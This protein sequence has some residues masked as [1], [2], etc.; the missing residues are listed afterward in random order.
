M[1]RGVNS[2]PPATNNDKPRRPAGGWRAAVAFILI[3]LAAL[4]LRLLFL[5]RTQLWG[6]EINFV[7]IL[8]QHALTPWQ[9]FLHYWNIVVGM[10]QLPLPGVLLNIHQQL[11]SLFIADP[12]RN[13]FLLRLPGALAGALAVALSYRLGR[14]ILP[15]IVNAAATAMMTACYFPVFYSREVYCYPFVILCAAG[16]FLYFW[17]CLFDPSCATAAFLALF[18]WLAALGLT[19]FGCTAGIAAMALLAGGWGLWNWRVA[20]DR[21]RSIRAWGTLGV[22]L[23]ALL[24]VAPYWWRIL[25]TDN[26]HI[27]GESSV[28]VARILHDVCSKFF[29]GDRLIPAALAWV[30]LL[31]GLGALWRQRE[32]PAPARMAVLLLLLIALFLT[33]LT[34]KSQYLSSRYF[35]VLTPLVYPVFAAGL[36]ALARGLAALFHRA[37]A[38]RAIMAGLVSAVLAA[39]LGLFLPQLYQVRE[40]GYPHAT[41]AAW[42]NANGEPGA[43]YFHDCGGWDLRYIPGYYPTPELTPAIWIAWNGP[44]YDAALKAIQRDLMARFPVSYYLRHPE[45][46]WAE[47]DRFYR[48]RVELRDPA[49]ARLRRYGIV[50]D[51]DTTNVN[52]EARDILYNTPADALDIARAAGRAVFL[53]YPGFACAPIAPEVYAR[54]IGGA[55]AELRVINLRDRAING[56][57]RIS[58]GILAPPGNYPLTLTLPAGVV[59]QTNLPS[60]NMLHFAMPTCRV[61]PEPSCIRCAVA[62]PNV[63]G[64]AI[65]DVEF[66]EQ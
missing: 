32:H 37:G 49:M 38:A 9:V 20:R 53:E 11:A 14:R 27:A 34:K 56:A 3:F 47:A 45:T 18:A 50:T 44:D 52:V 35:A 21:D 1:M 42:L 66:A 33:V 65:L 13:I 61:P 58:L 43:P 4:I 19:H 64:I 22:C 51:V 48:R 5:G 26:P 2:A 36:W 46:A 40:K 25:T 10:A 23:L 55:E 57:F 31:A 63:E 29:L 17:K 15:G 28:A 16:G 8:A 6:D 7:N 60:A 12:A 59:F 54:V 62:G 39:H 24:P 41:A 30:V